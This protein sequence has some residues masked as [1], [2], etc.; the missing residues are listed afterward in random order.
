M[1]QHYLEAAKKVRQIPTEELT[2]FDLFVFAG[3]AAGKPV[4]TAVQNADQALFRREGITIKNEN[5]AQDIFK[6]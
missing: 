2:I 1:T 6:P 5:S 4:D 3:L